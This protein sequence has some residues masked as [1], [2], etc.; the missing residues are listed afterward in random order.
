MQLAHADLR[1]GVLGRALR[2]SGLALA[3]CL[4]L[5]A[6]AGC[7]VLGGSSAPTGGGQ[8]T[9][10]VVPG[11]DTAPLMVA[12]DDGLFRQ[13]GLTVTVKQF[14]SVAQAYR[15]LQHG[16]ADV[17]AGDYTSFFYEISVG[18]PLRLVMDG[19]DAGAGTMQVLTLPGSGVSS[20]QSLQGKTVGTP[21]EQ[22]LIDTCKNKIC[23]KPERHIPG[24]SS[25][26]PDMPDTNDADCGS[27][28]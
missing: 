12:V 24:C 22:P 19:Y 21:S 17:A 1:V 3:L 13:Q 6:A 23:G 7:H 25:A 18:A 20:P 4:A 16:T 28:R 5:V 11:I 14:P 27:C 10:A 15:A 8:L 9:V 26:S 2:R